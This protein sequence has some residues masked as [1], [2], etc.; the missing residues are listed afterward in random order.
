MLN[1]WVN[2]RHVAPPVFHSDVFNLAEDSTVSVHLPG[3]PYTF[4]LTP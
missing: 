4:K 3:G 1:R 2:T